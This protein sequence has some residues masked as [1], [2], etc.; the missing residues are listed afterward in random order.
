FLVELVHARDGGATLINVFRTGRVSFNILT[1][2]L[3]AADGALHR[4]RPQLLIVITK[5]PDAVLCQPN[6]IILVVDCEGARVV[7]VKLFDVL[8]ENADTKTMESR[9]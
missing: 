6:G 1:T 7:F 3:G 5:I 4:T 9:D 8:A 2:I